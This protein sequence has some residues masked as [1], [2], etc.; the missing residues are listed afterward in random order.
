MASNRRMGSID[1]EMG[2]AMLNAAEEVLKEEGY[3]ALTSRRIANFLGIKQRL[4]YY[5]FRSM[6]ELIQETFKRL[7]IRELARLQAAI[8]SDRPLHEV[9]GI[10]INT[11][12]A[13]LISE[14]MAL[15]NHN[16]GVRNEVINF[17]EESRRLQVKA[18]KKAMAKNTQ[19][20]NSLPPAAIAI[21]GTSLALTLNRES[22]LGVK[23]GHAAVKK[24]IKQYFDQLEP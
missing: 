12:D 9:W 8:S 2:E 24:V 23:Q 7:S 4:L 19:D 18:L 16:E 17:I 13:R 14:F 3:G 5:Y 20:E 21:I 6:D 22:S 15:A 10:C 1:S 11:S